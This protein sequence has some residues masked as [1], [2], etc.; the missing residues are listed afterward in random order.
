VSEL[1]TIHS[2]LAR[3]TNAV[4]FYDFCMPTQIIRV[5]ILAL[6]LAVTITAGLHAQNSR[7][8]SQIPF[9]G[10]RSDGQV[11]PLASPKGAVK[12]VGLAAGVA[13]QLAYYKAENGFG[14]LS[15]RGWYCF[16]T[17]G[18][19]GSSLFVSPGPIND[20]ELFT[21]DWKGFSGPAIQVSVSAGDTSGR[22]TVA[23]TIARVFPDRME[24]VREV[25]SEGI[26]PAS[27]FPT[28]P[29][30]T[31]TLQRRGKDI[32]EFETPANTKGLGS[33]SRLAINSG[34]IQGVVILFGEEP[35]LVQLSIRLPN[36]YQRLGQTII[37]RL[38]TEATDQHSDK[39]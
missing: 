33:Q 30:A 13:D 1:A 22:F 2:E 32:V 23:K 10:C 12:I 37:Q 8:A 16:S 19:N 36:R 6:L 3:H 25:V 21:S 18:S 11:G 31:D 20:K 17:Y 14:T 24:F 7:T 15:P 38:E 9:V 39:E 26:E 4:R 28:A 29:Y 35:N 27:S 34:P 5:A